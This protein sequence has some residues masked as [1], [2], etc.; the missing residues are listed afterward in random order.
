MGTTVGLDDQAKAAAVTAVGEATAVRLTPPNG[1]TLARGRCAAAA[2][3][4]PCATTAPQVV[5]VVAVDH[6]EGGAAALVAW[7]WT[8]P[9][10]ALGYFE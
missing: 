10:L 6:A 1:T 7:I 8:Y 4:L 5:A 2:D 3:Q 9:E